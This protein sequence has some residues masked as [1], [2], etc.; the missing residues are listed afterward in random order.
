MLRAKPNVIVV[1][2]LFVQFYRIISFFFFYC[3]IVP[4]GAPLRSKEN[5]VQKRITYASWV[6]D[7]IEI[8]KVPFSFSLYLLMLLLSLYKGPAAAWGLQLWYCALSVLTVMWIR[9]RRTLL[10]S[11][12]R[13]GYCSMKWREKNINSYFQG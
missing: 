11:Q 10:I 9:C 4:G 6:W 13:Y 1:S 12:S 3:R 5:I 8:C 7:R 2:Y